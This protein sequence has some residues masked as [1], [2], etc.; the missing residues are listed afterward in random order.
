MMA[1]KYD[2][3][4]TLKKF[5]VIGVEIIVA[6]VIVYLTDNSLFLGLVP[7]FEALKNWLKHRKK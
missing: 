1:N 3:K 2:W 7:A 6:G 5:I 4:K